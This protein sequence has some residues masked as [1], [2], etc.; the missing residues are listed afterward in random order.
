[1]AL[2]STYS[3]TDNRV[4]VKPTE[5]GKPHQRIKDAVFFPFFGPIEF[6]YI[7]LTCCLSKC[8]GLGSVNT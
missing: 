2:I 4:W 6:H 7:N 8:I 1:M 3:Q 5:S